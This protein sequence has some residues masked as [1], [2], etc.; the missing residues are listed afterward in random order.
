MDPWTSWNQPQNTTYGL[1][2]INLL[3]VKLVLT[4]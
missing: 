2:R 3:Y 4:S 1:L